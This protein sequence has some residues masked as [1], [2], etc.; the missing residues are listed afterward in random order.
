MASPQSESGGVG[1]ARQIG[2][3]YRK[4]TRE[5]IN[6]AH[7]NVAERE[8]DSPLTAILNTLLLNVLST[9]Y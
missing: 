2:R 7:K 6:S 1:K 5:V 8:D 9:I 3:T 4:E